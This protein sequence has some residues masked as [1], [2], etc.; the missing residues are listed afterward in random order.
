MELYA[1]APIAA[2]SEILIEYVPN[3]ITKTRAER[4]AVLTSH[5]GFHKC[6]CTACE[7]VASEAE[8]LASDARRKKLL[9]Y[10]NSL[11]HIGTRAHKLATMESMRLLLVEEK[12]IGPPE[13]EDPSISNAFAIYLSMQAQKAKLDSV[14]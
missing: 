13:F 10:V 4:R 1:I 3:L 2:D 7:G 12:Y 8:G 9:E 5:F 6:M 11:S 14:L